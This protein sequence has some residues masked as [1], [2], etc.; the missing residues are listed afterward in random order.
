MK[1]NSFIHSLIFVTITR[2]VLTTDI[3]SILKSSGSILIVNQYSASFV[4]RKKTLWRASEVSRIRRGKK[5]LMRNDSNYILNEHITSG[6]DVA[7]FSSSF[8]L[9]SQSRS[10]VSFASKNINTLESCFIVEIE[11]VNLIEIDTEIFH[12]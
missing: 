4:T 10:G 9:F 2:P 5:Y 8:L 6:S 12:V 3:K 11:V 7:I 1:I